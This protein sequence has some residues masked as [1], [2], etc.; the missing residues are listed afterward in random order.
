MRSISRVIFFITFIGIIGIQF[1]SVIDDPQ[2]LTEADPNCPI[3]LA[4]STQICITPQ[5]SISFT[6]DIILYL[7]EKSALNQAKEEYIS[8]ISIRAPPLS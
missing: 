6:P 1:A 2:H 8:I 4:A 5:I 7:I 3:C